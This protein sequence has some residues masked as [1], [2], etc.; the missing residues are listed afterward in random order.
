M[1]IDKEVRGSR[2][3]IHVRVNCSSPKRLSQLLIKGDPGFQNDCR[4]YLK[5]KR[6]TVERFPQHFLNVVAQTTIKILRSNSRFITCD[7]MLVYISVEIQAN[8]KKVL[9]EL[10]TIDHRGNYDHIL[11]TPD[12]IILNLFPKNFLDNFMDDENDLVE[13]ITHELQHHADRKFFEIR[14]NIENRFVKLQVLEKIS[15]RSKIV[16]LSVFK[17]RIEGLARF[18]QFHYGRFGLID[19]PHGDLASWSLLFNKIP[20]LDFNELGKTYQMIERLS[21]Q[22]GSTMIATILAQRL[23]DTG[24]PVYISRSFERVKEPIEKLKDYYLSKSLFLYSDNNRKVINVAKALIQELQG[25]THLA[26]L[27]AYDEACNSLGIVNPGISKDIYIEIK[28]KCFVRSKHEFDSM[29]PALK[30]IL[31]KL[32]DK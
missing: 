15:Y 5:R 29:P 17:L 31:L 20:Y 10:L 22:A 7:N 6:L 26:F 2:G 25:E 8:F 18:S 21:Y 28:K 4:D 16:I 12:K 23:H 11:S 14:D 27:N 1:Y 24:I 19:M 9:R 32:H 13:L 3:S 30:D